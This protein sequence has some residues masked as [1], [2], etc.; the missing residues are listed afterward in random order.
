MRSRGRGLSPVPWVLALSLL[1]AL[2]HPMPVVR[3]GAL[4][5]LAFTSLGSLNLGGGSIVINSDALTI[6]GAASF[7]GVLHDQ[8]PSLQNG[9]TDFGRQVAVFD[10]SNINLAAGVTITLTGS[11]PVARALPSWC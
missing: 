5:P 9:V 10:F 1:V 4:D 7:V 3:A 2:L 8:G 11:R 6:T